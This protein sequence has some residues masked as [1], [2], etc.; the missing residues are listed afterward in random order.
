[1]NKADSYDVHMKIFVKSCG[2]ENSR[3][4]AMSAVST[5]YCNLLSGA[6]PHYIFKYFFVLLIILNKHWRK[7]LNYTNYLKKSK[8]CVFAFKDSNITVLGL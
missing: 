1:M 5:L 2:D 7:K 3:N 6:K 4:S 8:Y